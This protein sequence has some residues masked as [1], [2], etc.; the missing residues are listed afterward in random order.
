MVER[1]NSSNLPS[2]EK[3]VAEADLRKR[4]PR[5]MRHNGV[6]AFRFSLLQHDLTKAVLR[7]DFTLPLT[8]ARNFC[9]RVWNLCKFTQRVFKAAHGW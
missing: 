1:V 4:F 2:E 7:V 5:G 8:E 6:D 3:A 9:N